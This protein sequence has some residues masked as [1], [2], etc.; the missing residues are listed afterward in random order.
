MKYIKT[1]A[2]SGYNIKTVFTVIT[3]SIIDKF[4]IDTLVDS[5][6]DR[7]RQCISLDQ[8]QKEKEKSINPS[9]SANPV[10][11]SKSPN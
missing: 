1:S 5:D 4:G 10:N 9:N 6:Q 11:S 7:L 8:K 2:A 3:E